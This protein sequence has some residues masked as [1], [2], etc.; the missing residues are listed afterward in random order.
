[1]TTTFCILPRKVTLHSWFLPIWPWPPTYS[2]NSRGVG[3]FLT[4][5]FFPNLDMFLPWTHTSPRRRLLHLL[6]LEFLPPWG[7]CAP[8]RSYSARRWT[9]AGE[10]MSVRWR[11]LHH[12]CQI[13]EDGEAAKPQILWV[14]EFDFVAV[15]RHIQVVFPRQ[16]KLLL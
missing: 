15:S 9:A 12:E 11:L 6:S 13:C 8:G 3:K 7:C 1:M 5:P 2:Q 4:P 16:F 14:W 10:K